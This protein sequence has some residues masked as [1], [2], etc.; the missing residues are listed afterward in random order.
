MTDRELL[1][2][3][4]KAAGMRLHWTDDEP[5]RCHEVFPPPFTLTRPTDGPLW[6]PLTDDGDALALAVRLR[7]NV[8]MWMPGRAE[9]CVLRDDRRISGEARG[10]DLCAAARRAI[11]L[12]AAAIAEDAQ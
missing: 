7:M 2:L 6:E 1:E 9:A 10:D 3:A 12:C 8:D 5:P 4:A 11:V